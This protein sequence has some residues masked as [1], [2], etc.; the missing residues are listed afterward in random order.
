[1]AVIQIVAVTTPQQQAGMRRVRDEVFVKEQQ[2]PPALEM[3]HDADSHHYLL[4]EDGQPVACGRWRIAGQKEGVP[5]AKI[6]RCAVLWGHRKL[7]YGKRMVQYIIGQIP[8]QYGVY[9]HAQTHARQFYERLGFKPDGDLF[10]EADIE[11]VR[12]R[13][14]R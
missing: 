11:H 3:E 12:M 7:G 8:A 4:L 10:F 14:K 6:E 9:L 13:L 1:M 5:Q 2:V